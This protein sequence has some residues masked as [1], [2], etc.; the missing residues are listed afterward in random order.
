[1][2][3]G[4]KAQV[5]LLDERRL[6]MMV[7]PKLY[8]GDLLDIVASH[9]NL[10]EKEYF[11]L[12]FLDET[13]HF[14][15]LQLDRKVL[16]HDFPKK[17]STGT[18]ILYFSVRFYIES[19]AYLRDKVTVELFY[20]QAKQAIFKGTVE[21]DS[22]TAF[23]LAAHVLQAAHGDY[24]DD[25]ITR[26]QLK[27]LPVLPTSIF[28]D[29]PSIQYCED[30]VIDHY[31]KLSGQSRGS[32]IVNYLSI[33]ETLPTYGIHYYE[34]KDKTGL[35]WWLGL[36]PK[37]IAQYDYADKRT[38]RK[39]FPWK[40]LENLYFRDRKF[41]IEVHDPK[42]VSVSR[43]TFGPGNVNVYAWFA[44]SALLTKTIWSMAVCQH[45]FYLDRKSS[46][47]HLPFVRSMT[48]LAA[49]ISQSTSSLPGSDGSSLGIRTSN[50]CHSLSKIS[51]SSK[52][53][54]TTE[55]LEIAR[56]AQRDMYAALKARKEALEE[57]LK[58]KTAELK[59]LCIREGDL[60]GE[61]P[62]ETPLIPGEMVPVVRKRMGTE[63]SLSS[64]IINTDRDEEE[65]EELAKLE[66]EFELQ[67]QITNAA[68]K[69]AKDTSAA[70]SVRKSRRQTYQKSRE[71][72][73][74]IEKRLNEMKYKK[75]QAL[76]K[77]HQ[78]SLDDESIGTAD[79]VSLDRQSIKSEAKSDS[80]SDI[81]AKTQESEKSAGLTSLS[82]LQAS[83]AKPSSSDSDK[84][85]RPPKT[86][87]LKN[88]K[89]ILEEPESGTSKK[90]SPVNLTKP[91]SDQNMASK[92]NSG[93][94]SVSAALLSKKKH[95]GNDTA[96]T[97]NA[98]VVDASDKE[99][100]K[101]SSKTESE[102]PSPFTSPAVQRVHKDHPK[103]TVITSPKVEIVEVE[104]GTPP[105][106]H[107]RPS[108]PSSQ[109]L[110]SMESQGSGRS[111]SYSQRSAYSSPSAS[112]QRQPNYPRGSSPSPRLGRQGSKDVGYTPNTVYSTRTHYRTL[113]YPT[114][115]S[116]VNSTSS[117]LSEY[118]NLSSTSTR[119]S[120]GGR[121]ARYETNVDSG[122][123][124]PMHNMYNV[125]TGSTAHAGH[126]Q[127]TDEL[128]GGGE[129]LY[130]G[131]DN[132]SVGSDDRGGFPARHNSL[133]GTYRRGSK[134]YP[135]YGSLERNVNTFTRQ[136]QYYL[137][138]QQQQQ[139]H[140]RQEE[141]LPEL[142]PSR[143]GSKRDSHSDFGDYFERD[144][145][146]HNMPH[147]HHQQH[148]HHHHQQHKQQH[149]H[150]SHPHHQQHQ[151]YS[152]IEEK[153]Y[154]AAEASI[155]YIDSNGHRHEPRQ[156]YETS[157]S[158]PSLKH[159]HHSGSDSPRYESPLQPNVKH[160]I[161]NISR[162][163]QQRLSVEREKNPERN[164]NRTNTKGAPES[165]KPVMTVTK[166]RPYREVTKPYELS[167]FYKYSEKLRRQ[168]SN[169]SPGSQSSG[170]PPHSGQEPHSPRS[171]YL[172]QR[173]PHHQGAAAA[174]GQGAT[175][176]EG[177]YDRPPLSPASYET[178]RERGLGSYTVQ[179]HQAPRYHTQTAGYHSQSSSSRQVQY[180]APQPMKC[181]PVLSPPP[182]GSNSSSSGAR[183]LH[184][185]SSELN[186]PSKLVSRDA[187]FTF[188]AGESLAEAFSEEML[189]WYEDQD[190]TIKP[191]TIV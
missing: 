10:K 21:C 59:L 106:E 92:E 73:Q 174:G 112:P 56:A 166:F 90:L 141:N 151:R 12:C 149:H 74:D 143:F 181:E 9:F 116:R 67:N 95:G 122:R 22:E 71:K 182:D 145:P 169:E 137:D 87:R 132:S 64:R 138:Q 48:E 79:S 109:S 162:D 117:N 170:T 191:A 176:S 60:T 161:M 118:D 160:D 140:Q 4:R 188:D 123:T 148:H 127:S 86:F 184:S 98:T 7:Q 94:Y 154:G 26:S 42:R 2:A 80:A 187:S 186:P 11:G 107:K 110:T 115:S 105:R 50:S 46:K 157:E 185:D 15:W 190:N 32:A 36:S 126:Y 183:R 103:V 131:G 34:V 133:E 13:N 35:P 101:S 40:Q 53:D 91:H 30:R 104:H 51:N 81:S 43:R 159:R 33:V 5:V 77:H 150:S 44:A 125:N 76:V 89:D 108:T 146:V 6:D 66:L 69:L 147:H 128:K 139:Q 144:R 156:W 31:K 24:E 142:T 68:L 70:K 8:A 88:L 57:A 130:G 61:L 121:S 134:E 173:T 75:G 97:V 96:K 114:F 179:S 1:M 25:D 78:P 63:F 47:A 83:V 155:P 136:Q 163:I 168:R 167:D 62:P 153:S 99:S 82:R 65:D 19:I 152:N 72:L 84:P 158:P 16:E 37:G 93:S 164:E 28:K 189:A 3:E 45:Q 55:Q 18:L 85:P 175:Y 129:G 23:E 135:R 171:P 172:S 178:V 39:V 124:V 49:E 180:T 120:S 27:K 20:L 54:L 29:H 177:G 38:P 100:S 17:Q 111:G 113:Q 102:Y 119:D 14:T 52:S 165:P 58:K 41:S